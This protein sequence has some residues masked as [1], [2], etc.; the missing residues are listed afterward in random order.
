[1]T[2][3]GRHQIQWRAALSK[4]RAHRKRRAAASPR[5]RRGATLVEFAAVAPVLFLFV[6]GIIELGRLVMVQQAITN[7]ARESCREASLITTLNSQ[8]V[9]TAARN[10]M[11]SVMANASDTQKVRVNISPASMASLSSGTPVSVDIEVDFSDVSWLPGS[12]LGFVVNPVLGAQA[13]QERE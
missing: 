7:A 10:V 12:I 13:T 9:D 4:M 8:D 5:Q 11:Q 3:L 6:F 1:M 2:C